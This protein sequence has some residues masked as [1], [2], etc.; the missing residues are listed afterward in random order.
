MLWNP[1]IYSLDIDVSV[2]N[3]VLTLEGTV[4]AYWKKWKA[5]NLLSDLRGVISITNHLVVVPGDGF[6]DKAIAADIESALK[7]NQYVDA[8]DI[9]VKVEEGH[10]TLTG[11]A[12][13]YYARMRA[14]S[15][16]MN[17]PGVI[18]VENEITGA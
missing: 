3:G 15:A 14:R 1:D 8:E 7:R 9:T 17:A 18:E 2:S 4:D 10:V 6:T 13:T 5:E 16:A 12:P 11:S